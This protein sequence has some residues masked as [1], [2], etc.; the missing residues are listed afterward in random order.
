VSSNNTA[1]ELFN[2]IKAIVDN[3]VSNRQVSA[4][5]TGVYNGSSVM[6]NNR[7]PVPMSMISGNMKSRL[8]P[9]DKVVLLRNDGG[10]EYYILEI[11]GKPYF[12]NNGE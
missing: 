1:N 11:T 3:Y 12:I 10:R 2:V 7:L 6:I 5:I 4:T 8:S 9:G